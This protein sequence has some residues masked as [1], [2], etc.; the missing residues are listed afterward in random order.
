MVETRVPRDLSARRVARQF[1]TAGIRVG[2][3]KP[4]FFCHITLI[5]NTWKTIGF[6]FSFCSLGLPTPY[7]ET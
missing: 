2:Q 5:I 6:A 4:S 1:P 7:R 3:A